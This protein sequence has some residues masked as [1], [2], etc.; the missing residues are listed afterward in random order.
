MNP[1]N[2]AK[3]I[4]DKGRNAKD[5]ETSIRKYRPIKWTI[6]KKWTNPLER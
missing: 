5:H 6:Y 1:H 3:V 2:Y 4:Y